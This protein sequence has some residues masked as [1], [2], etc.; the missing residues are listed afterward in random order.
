MRNI[1][2][3]VLNVFALLVCQFSQAFCANN[4]VPLPFYDTRIASINLGYDKALLNGRIQ[5]DNGYIFRIVDYKERDDNVLLTW[6]KGDRIVLVPHTKGSQLF[7]SIQNA[8][9]IGKKDKTAVEPYVIF[10]AL[11]T[12][13]SGLKIVEITHNGKFVKLSD[14][15]VWE[16]SWY[17]QLSTK[18]WEIGNRVLIQ[19]DGKANSYSFINFDVAPAKNSYEA[20]GTFVAL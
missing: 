16:F 8:Q 15:T 1:N 5:I 19:G 13:D 6:Q 4:T 7:L 9:R 2:L 17:Y 20:T 10:D 11:E 18:H 3:F 14:N 12:P